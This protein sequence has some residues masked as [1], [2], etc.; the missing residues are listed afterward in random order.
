MGED[1]ESVV[2]HQIVRLPKSSVRLYIPPRGIVLIDPD[3]VEGPFSQ[4]QRWQ[5]SEE[6]FHCK[7]LEISVET[8]HSYPSAQIICAMGDHGSSWYMDHL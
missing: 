3:V 7:R 1:S 2:V 4:I 8:I 6:D 5:N